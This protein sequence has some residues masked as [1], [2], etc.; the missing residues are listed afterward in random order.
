MTSAAADQ[1][2]EGAGRK[3]RTR[4]NVELA[5]LVFATL[6]GLAAYANV[7]IV[8]HGKLPPQIGWY[9]IGL[10]LVATITH[11]FVRIFARYADPLLLPCVFLLNGIGLVFIH[12]LDISDSSGGNPLMQ[13]IYTLVGIAL[14]VA[15]LVLVRD[16]RLLRRFTYTAGVAGLV[17]LALPAVLPASISAVHGAKLWI[18][19]AGFSIQPGEFAKLLLMVFFAGYLV[20]KRDV[21]SLAGRRVLFVDLPRAKDLGP[22][23]VAWVASLGILVFEHDLGSSLLFFGIFVAMLY[24]ATGRVSWIIIGL[25]LFGGGSFLAYHL[26]AHVRERFNIWLHPFKD[27]DNS[28][29]LIQGL[30]GMADGGITGTGLGQGRP[31]LVPFAKSDF[32]I[33]GLGEELGLAGLMAIL[34]VYLVVVARGMRIALASRDGFG[35]L[36]AAGLS[37]AVALQVFVVVGGVTRLIPLTGLTTPFLSYGGSSLLANWA[38]IALLLRVS[39]AARRPT[40]DPSSTHRVEPEDSPTEVVQP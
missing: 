29:Q 36:L 32:I 39:D 11:V 25:V 27:P 8:M 38:L 17:L 23:L 22:V 24:I 9:A 3:V 33:A 20:A 40:P 13:F 12:R 5:M 18:R 2:R 10:V 1:R 4:R 6:I 35:K 16:H 19:I 28:Y 30:F 37:V 34:L 26:F 31:T 14:F 7:E 15:V 21:L